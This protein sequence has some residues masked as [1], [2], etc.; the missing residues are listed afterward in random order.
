LILAIDTS[1]ISSLEEI[2]DFVLKNK[3]KLG[4]ENIR[5]W[6]KPVDIPEST[7]RGEKKKDND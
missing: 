3:I 6:E 5:T 2:N 4:E 1:Q 7:P